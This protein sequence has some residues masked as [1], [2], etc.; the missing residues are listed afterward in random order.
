MAHAFQPIPG[1]PAFGNIKSTEYASNYTKNKIAR[2]SYC[3]DKKNR[4]CKKGY[5]QFELLTY[6]KGFALSRYGFCAGVSPLNYSDL[7]AGLY[8]QSNLQNVAVVSDVS[9]GIVPTTIDPC[10]CPFYSYYTI[11]PK[12]EL[13][14]NTACGLNNFTSY[15]TLKSNTLPPPPTNLSVTL[16]PI[17][18]SSIFTPAL[19]EGET[20]CSVIFSWQPPINNGGSLISE[21]VVNYYPQDDESSSSLINISNPSTDVSIDISIPSTY[22]FQVAAVNLTGQGPFAQIEYT[23]PTYPDAPTDAIANFA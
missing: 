3:R 23:S 19:A 10:V 11:D 5:S 6:K 9:Y 13:F 14:G 18:P 12:G 2:I 20:S 15:M 16:D 8:T 4:N 17:I 22:V 7:T 21:Y 1:K